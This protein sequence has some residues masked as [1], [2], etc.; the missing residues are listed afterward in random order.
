[1][2]GLVD[3]VAVAHLSAALRVMA[4]P[5]PLLTGLARSLDTALALRAASG[6]RVVVNAWRRATWRAALSWLPIAACMAI[7]A[8]IAFVPVL[9]AAYEPG[10]AALVPLFVQ[11][12]ML[13]AGVGLGPAYRALDAVGR[14]LGIGLAAL[15]ITLLPGWWLVTGWGVAGAAWFHALRTA[16]AIG[17]GIVAVQGLARTRTPS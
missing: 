4:V 16:V 2:L 14:S 12:A 17:A 6:A 7:A 11:S 8:W 1:M 5:A 13:G 9:G 15:A 10:R 3:T